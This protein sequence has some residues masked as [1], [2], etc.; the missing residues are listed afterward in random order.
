MDGS[1]I[2]TQT[3]RARVGD[4]GLAWVA[5]VVIPLFPALWNGICSCN[6]TPAGHLA[7]WYEA[8]LVP[9]RSTVFGLYLHDGEGSNFWINLSLQA[10]ATLWVLQR[11]LCV[12]GIPSPFGC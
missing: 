4:Q 1:S 11:T 5:V 12:L 6:G 8:Y 7:R 9:T 3:L 2:T 10:P